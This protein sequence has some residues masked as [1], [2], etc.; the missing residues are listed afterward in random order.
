MTLTESKLQALPKKP[1]LRY[2]FLGE[3]FQRCEFT[4][5]KLKG[6]FKVNG[7]EVHGPGRHNF[8]LAIQVIYVSHWV[9]RGGKVAT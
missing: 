6:F 1:Q 2:Y 5:F 8:V 7:N 9:A 4:R 3:L